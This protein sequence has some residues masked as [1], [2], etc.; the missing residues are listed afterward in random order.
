MTQPEAGEE[1]L[2]SVDHAASLRL[3]AAT[4]V[5]RMA[6]VVD[7]RPVIVVLNHL[8]E[9]EHV[10]FR[11]RAD[12]LLSRLTDE[13]HAVH[14]VY[15]VDSA[16]SPG[17]SGWSVIASGTLHRETDGARVARA[18]DTIEAWAHGERDT[19]LRLEIDDLTG[20]RV[21]PL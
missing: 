18:R 2:E 13:G 14:A 21:G 11:T 3:L 4:D 15:E 10:L 8:L 5:G 20:R 12:A 9:G 1:L 16:F 19:V 7:G 6:V 17:R